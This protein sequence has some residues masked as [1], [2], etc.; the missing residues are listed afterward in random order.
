MRGFNQSRLLAEHLGSVWQL[1]LEAGLLQRVRDTAPQMQ[2]PPEER[3]TNIRGAFCADAAA[4]HR[5]IGLLD[6]VYTTGST[7]REC[8]RM[9]KRAGAERVLVLTLARALPRVR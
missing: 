3:R 4:Q 9:L 7:L 5:S 8:S 6:D 1:P 2:L